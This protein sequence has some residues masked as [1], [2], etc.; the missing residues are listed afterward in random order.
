M[1]NKCYLYAL[2]IMPT[3]TTDKFYVLLKIEDYDKD[4]R[5][6]PL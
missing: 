2:S 3:F 4:Q 5:S 6:L 1:G